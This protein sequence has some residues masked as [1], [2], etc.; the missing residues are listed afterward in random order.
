M[1]SF[2]KAAKG[3]PAGCDFRNSGDMWIACELCRPTLAKMAAKPSS[4]R[5]FA[6]GLAL[7]RATFSAAPGV[8][9]LLMKMHES[10][11]LPKSRN[12]KIHSSF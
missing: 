8:D 6:L 12:K 7:S 4:N 9:D 3:T 1:Q 10:N 11:P 2:P 5:K